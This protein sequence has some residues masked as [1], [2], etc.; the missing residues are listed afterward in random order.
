MDTHS[1]AE[2]EAE[3]SAGGLQPGDQVTLVLSATVVTPFS[4]TPGELIIAQQHIYF[5]EEA[6]RALA[7][8]RSSSS[9][10]T[11]PGLSALKELGLLR[12]DPGQLPCWP[13]ERLSMVMRRRYLLRHVAL[14]LFYNNGSTVML[15]FDSPN[16]CYEAHT[17]LA[18][19]AARAMDPGGVV[20]PGHLA[21]RVQPWHLPPPWS[22]AAWT[23]AASARRRAPALASAPA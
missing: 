13:H 8:S 6:V 9:L 4:L 3:S 20:M 5:K 14:E 12:R 11:P 17:L 7:T 1:E 19:R 18:A 21:P 10:D 16:L 15:A 2:P 23:L 22:R